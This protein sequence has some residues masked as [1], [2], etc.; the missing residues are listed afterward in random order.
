MKESWPQT[1]NWTPYTSSRIELNGVAEECRLPRCGVDARFPGRVSGCVVRSCKRS[2]MRIHCVFSDRLLLEARTGCACGPL[3]YT[4]Y[5]WDRAY[6]VG[7]MAPS[8]VSWCLWLLPRY[9]GAS[10]LGSLLVRRKKPSRADCFDKATW[11]EWLPYEWPWP[12]GDKR[13]PL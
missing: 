7:D 9:L 13:R 8:Q 6:E 3:S 10:A 11:P 12:P 4:K 1:L 5:I 2:W